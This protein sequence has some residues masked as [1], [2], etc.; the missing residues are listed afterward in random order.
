MGLI[1][2]A[3]SIEEINIEGGSVGLDFF[4]AIVLVVACFEDPTLS[5]E[6]TGVD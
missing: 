5:R 2:S 6:C 3:K 1:S 4:F